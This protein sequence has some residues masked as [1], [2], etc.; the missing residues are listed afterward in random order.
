MA[1]R[2]ILETKIHVI[3]DLL[4]SDT[5]CYILRLLFGCANL[6]EKSHVG[7][8]EEW[9]W[10]KSNGRRQRGKHVD[11][12]PDEAEQETG[13]DLWIL[14]AFVVLALVD[15]WSKVANAGSRQ[16]HT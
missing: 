14:D 9:A 3:R 12:G 10:V 13:T 7:L 4:R 1:V 2:R 5:W 11:A 16:P 15:P 6:I 8:A